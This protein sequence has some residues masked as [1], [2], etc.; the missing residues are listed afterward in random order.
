M[1]MLSEEL[2]RAQMR[3]RSRE[4]YEDVRRQRLASAHRSLR[5]AERSAHQA[6]LVLAAAR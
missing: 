1:S 4:I 6:R 5:R 3:Q 2:A